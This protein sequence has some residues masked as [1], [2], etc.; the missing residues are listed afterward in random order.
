M[1][2]ADRVGVLRAAV[3]EQGGVWTRVRA[4]RLFDHAITHERARMLLNRLVDEGLMT[5]VGKLGREWTVNERTA[6]PELTVIRPGMRMTRW[7]PVREGGRLFQEF[8]FSGPGGRSVT[9][10]VDD[11]VMRTEGISV[12]PRGWL[13]PDVDG[14]PGDLFDPAGPAGGDVS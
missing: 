5:R 7:E 11:E 4:Q 13:E 6:R 12:R 3:L 2:A 9:L 14:S 8:T 10:L 1:T